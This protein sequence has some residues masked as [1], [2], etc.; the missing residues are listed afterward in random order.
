VPNHETQTHSLPRARFERR[1]VWLF[2]KLNYASRPYH[3]IFC[4]SCVRI[5]LEAKFAISSHHYFYHC[6]WIRHLPRQL[7]FLVS[8]FLTIEK[9]D[10]HNHHNGGLFCVFYSSGSNRSCFGKRV[11]EQLSQKMKSF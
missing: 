8:A 4:E 1:F 10:L 9:F 6:R 7:V 5:S 2:Q 11:A 3:H